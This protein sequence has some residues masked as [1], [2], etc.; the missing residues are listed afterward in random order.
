MN[1]LQEILNNNSKISSNKIALAHHQWKALGSIE[2][3][4]TAKLGGHTQYCEQGHLQG[5]WYNSCKHRFCPQCNQ[6]RKSQWVDNL[7]RILLNCSH[8][9]IVFTIPSEL[10][11]LWRYNRELMSDVLFKCVKLTLK[12]F[13]KDER[14]LGAMPGY[15][16][17]LHTWGRSLNLHPHIHAVVSHGGLNEKGQWKEPKK[18][19]LFPQKPVMLV[20]RGKML[21]MLKKLVSNGDLKRPKQALIGELMNILQRLYRKEWTVNFSERYD[22]ARG[23]AKYLGKYVKGG[24]FN[25]KQLK[26]ENGGIKFSYSSHQ[27]KRRESL[28]LSEEAFVLR[29]MEHVAMPRKPTFRYGGLYVSS[30]REKLNTARKALGQANVEAKTPMDWLAYL[31]KISRVPLCKECGKLVNKMGPLERTA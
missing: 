22:H 21:G 6:I 24:P 4:R 17:A 10:N 7:E 15:L 25:L 26:P 8:H 19:H 14:Y 3:C 20:F 30:V 31:E 9:H 13:A 27:T 29:L 1:Q 12:E 28:N 2:R 5:V 11:E 16:M 18:K 23:V